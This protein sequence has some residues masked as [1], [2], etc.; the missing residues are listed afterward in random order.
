MLQ[1]YLYKTHG[2]LGGIEKCD[3]IECFDLFN[4]TDVHAFV[5]LYGIV[6][7]SHE[8]NIVKRRLFKPISTRSFLLPTKCSNQESKNLQLSYDNLQSS[9]HH[10]ANH[11]HVQPHRHQNMEGASSSSI[12]GHS[13][14]RAVDNGCDCFTNNLNGTNQDN[15]MSSDEDED[16]GY[17]F[18]RI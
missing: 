8:L 5:N 7:L 1:C 15:N 2:N 18:Q 12:D 14:S 6:Q 17:L 3:R 4:Q 10:C 16:D 11:M 13:V 9:S